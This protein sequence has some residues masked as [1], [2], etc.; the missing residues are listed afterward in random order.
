M[1]SAIPA[2][3]AS[4]PSPASPPAAAPAPPRSGSVEDRGATR[5]DSVRAERWSSRGGTKVLGDVD[6]GTGDLGGLSS[7]RG[8]VRGG[9][10]SAQGTLL[11]GGSVELEALL[12]VD[13]SATFESPVRAA[14]I[15]LVGTI[16]VSGDLVATGSLRLRGSLE[17]SGR[18]SAPRIELDGRIRAGGDLEAKELIGTLR[19]ESRFPNLRADRIVLR[20]GGRFG[21]RGSLTVTSIEATDVALEGVEAEYLR[22][23]RIDLGPGC[24][25]ARSDGTVSRVHP[26]S[27]IGPVSR[28]PRPYGLSR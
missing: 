7:I 22:A 28:S 14:R 12:S 17:V 23:E 26:S 16:S 1:A 20:R 11:V 21:P 9:T 8:R 10:L 4:P 24:Q 27:H 6:I 3:T 25:I 19:G 5:H 13:G 18:I 2:P 15:E